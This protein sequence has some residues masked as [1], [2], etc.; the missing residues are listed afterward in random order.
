VRSRLHRDL[1]HATSAGVAWLVGGPGAG[2]TTLAACWAAERGPRTLWYRADAGDADPASA[3]GYF[4]QLA[5]DRRRS[6]SLPAF[7]PLELEQLERFA[8]TFFRAFFGTIPAAATLVIDD[9]HTAA[10]TEFD[11]LLSAAIHEVPPDVAFVIAS[12]RE[13]EGPL[14]DHVVRGTLRLVEDKALAFSDDEAVELLDGRVERS[15]ARHLRAQVDGWAAGILL[16][17]QAASVGDAAERSAPSGR[18]RI[19]SY[20]EERV[21]ASLTVPEQRTL[22]A[23]ALLP[24]VDADALERMG[25]PGGEALEF[26]R[27]QRAFVTRL[28]RQPPSWRLHELLR[29]ALLRRFDD[30]GIGDARWRDALRRAAAT[31]AAERGHTRRAVEL[32]LAAGDS[33]AARA[34][35]E[36]AAPGLVKSMR[37]HELDAIADA[38]APFVADSF[39]LQFAL[40]ESAWQ[41][42]DAK[43]AVGRFERAYELLVAGDD[44]ERDRLRITAA[45]IAAILEG[46]QEFEGTDRWMERLRRHMDAR[47]TIVDPEQGLRVDSAWLQ[48]TNMIWSH[49]LGGHEPVVARM[50]DALRSDDHL[51]PNVVIAASSVLMEAAGYRLSDGTLFREIVAAT[52]PW[53]R[54]SSLAPLAK[55]GW[56]VTYAPLGRRW[57][58]P[59]VQL[60]AADPAAALELAIELAREHGGRS[61]AFSAALFLA[62]MAVATNDRAKAGR[63]LEALREFVDASRPRQAI[64]LLEVESNVQALRGDWPQARATIA[65]ARALAERHGFPSSQM[66]NIE[67]YEQRLAIAS[68]AAPEARETLLRN[69]ERYPEG[70]RREFALIL[71]DVAAAAEGLRA[72]GAIA[73]GL[74]AAVMQRARAYDWPGFAAHLGP[75]A[76]RLCSDAIRRGIEPDF[77]RRVVRD[78][79]LA[80]PAPFEEHWPWAMRVRALGGFDVEVDGEP[81]DWGPRAQRKPL[82]LLKLLVAQGPGPADAAI[83]IDALWPDADG[84]GARASFDMTV[85]R[86]RKLLQRHDALKL[87]GSHIGLD[88]SVVWVDVFAF[89]AGATDAYPGPLFGND[90]LQPW[91]AAA[92]EKLHQRFLRRAVE[93]GRALERQGRSDEALQLFEAAL[94]QDALAEELYQGAIR[95]YI[96]AN[97]PADALRV[98][99]R[100]REQLSIVLGVAPSASTQALVTSIHGG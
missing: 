24:E 73:P 31:L 88:T 46:W 97:R 19:R 32:W 75:V 44:V 13:P 62:H 12:R 66:W 10:G 56:L 35:A 55:A 7:Q 30:G 2:K 50:L 9:A 23:A 100:C 60:P 34:T 5:Q 40:A 99:R 71:A 77:A 91:W 83:V 68:G 18:E 89:L 38:L 58:T 22:A 74:V 70:N 43:T 78:R 96:A 42:N 15:R 90:A 26:L 54:Q 3:F 53:L 37:P 14:L 69:S 4:A 49:G 29:E 48:A 11:V 51:D 41:R 80:P 27:K 95:C 57:P 25:L 79:R 84:A 52:A 65:R 8:R 85:M 39:P 59:G 93:R 87:D 17:A 98:F 47:A 92:R 45:A 82:D 67:I 21:V 76:A 86:L 16:F 94:A 36:A 28:D 72:D 61:L 63:R 6:A 1:D 64:N 20:F 33:G 81:L